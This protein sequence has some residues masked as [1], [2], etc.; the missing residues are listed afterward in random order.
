MRMTRLALSLA[1][2]AV[3]AGAAAETVGSVDTAFKLI[4]PDHKVVVEVFDDPAVG[5]V[6]CYLSRAKTGGIKGAVGLAEDKAESSVACRQ[7]GAITFNG[8]IPRQDE[9]FSERASIFFKH[10]RVVRMVDTKR[11]ALVYLVYSDRL[12]DGSPK[13]S[14]TA[15]PVPV[16]QPIPLK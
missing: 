14:V 8:K 13:N 4:G 2:S 16:N 7:V 1:L 6:S 10:V 12:I 5:G 15:V 3:A 11:N 9:V